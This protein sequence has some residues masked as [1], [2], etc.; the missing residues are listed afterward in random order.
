MRLTS[1]SYKEFE[2]AG[3][4][5]ELL[6]F[7][8]QNI[9]LIVGR[10][11][12][13]KSRTLNVINGLAR[14]LSTPGAVAPEDGAFEA[15]FIDPSNLKWDY[16]LSV[17]GSVVLE[18]R[19]AVD[20]KYLLNRGRDGIGTIFAEKIDQNLDF[21]MPEKT[22]AV[23]SR[24]DAIQHP[25]LEPL[26][27]WAENTYYYPCHTE[28]GKSHLQV[29]SSEVSATYNLKDH[30]QTLAVFRAG[31]REFYSEFLTALQDDM[32]SLGYA[33][34]EIGEGSPQSINFPDLGARC[35]YVRESDIDT[36]VDQFAMSVGM[37][38]ALAI[39][40]QIN[41]AILSSSAECILIDDI[42]EGLDFERSS[43]LIK[44][45]IRKISKTDTQV[46]MTTNDR[47]VMNGTDLKYWT[48]LRRE[49]TKVRPLNQRN[50]PEEFKEF[51]Y[52]GLNNFDFF[53]RDFLVK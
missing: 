8:L 50:R 41:Y 53:A 3:R 35:L 7:D 47:Y 45:I 20:G 6:P 24:Q 1:F 46:L 48:V 37:F 2:G 40:I 29:A 51:K 13:G 42:G 30:N 31:T 25:F 28:L 33:V 21:Q 23:T 43:A 36:P 44:L 22:I 38:R 52:T 4:Y 49:G 10:N 11:A 15:S 14:I 16:F 12:S 17:G 32:N 26:I 27:S 34:T 9:N 19:L 39:L 5:W 18:E